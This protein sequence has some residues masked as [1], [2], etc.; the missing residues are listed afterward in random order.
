VVGELS[1]RYAKDVLRWDDEKALAF[2]GVMSAASG[3]I[4][5]QDGN[6]AGAVN[7]ANTMGDNA[8]RYNYLADHQEAKKA[9]ELAECKKNPSC[10]PED[11]ESKW[12]K[13]SRKQNLAYALGIG[14]GVGFGIYE[15]GAG[16]AHALMNP[17]DTYN[18]LQALLSNPNLK[19]EVKNLLQ[20]QY[21]EFNA[22]YQKGDTIG[23]Q[24]AGQLVGQFAVNLALAADAA[25]TGVQLAVV[26]GKVV[27]TGG[28][29]AIAK[30]GGKGAAAGAK[31]DA[32]GL[33]FNDAV[34]PFKNSDLTNVGR[35]LTKHPE[36]LNQT[37][38]TLRQTIR[39]DAELN[40]AGAKALENI[41]T[42][43]VRTESVLPRYGNTVTYQIPGGFGVRFEAGTN[44][45]I[46]FINP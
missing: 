39:T 15:A 41:M 12:D 44:K 4:V 21:N 34:S 23:S 35:A 13:V 19:P 42:N 22:E 8:A 5:A 7:L 37:K 6:D 24:N 14:Q 2:A 30:V 27:A 20:Q 9:K 33:M 45:F 1:A 38:E 3:V 25:V 16:L 18:Q 26:G 36:V 32:A 40:I 17:V 28:K 10:N 11:I 31:V 29:A 43:G 46:G